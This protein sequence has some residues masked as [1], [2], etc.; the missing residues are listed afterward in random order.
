MAE[1]RGDYFWNTP[2]QQKPFSNWKSCAKDSPSHPL[3]L[4]EE[5]IWN[6]WERTFS[7]YLPWQIHGELQKV[8]HLWPHWIPQG[9]NA[10]ALG[11]MAQRMGETW[12]ES[13]V[14]MQNLDKAKAILKKT[15][16][17]SLFATFSHVFSNAILSHL[18][19][20]ITK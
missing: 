12:V 5:E 13:E 2:S 16:I 20:Q 17:S 14:G 11:P 6:L 3:H 8:H 10:I 19:V 4:Q 9:S 1:V 7:P 18:V 15:S